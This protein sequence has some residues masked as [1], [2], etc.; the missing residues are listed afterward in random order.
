MSIA[1][2]ID[3]LTFRKAIIAWFR[4]ATDLLTVWREQSE[5]KADYPYGG[6][7]I[8]NG[9]MLLA[10]QWETRYE[11]DLGRD[12]GEEIKLTTRVPCNFVISCQAYVRKKDARDPNQDAMSYVNKAQSALS[13]LSVQ[14]TLENFNVT[15]IRTSDVQNISSVIGDAHV[16]R[17]NID[18]TFGATLLLEEFTGYIERVQTVSTT[19]G[20]DQIIGG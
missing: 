12:P 17:A 14:T 18:V 16:S 7:Q 19:L 9:P 4:N 11:T 15:Y 20:V 10:P 3:M 6:L 1:A 2:P 5:P 8:L 13:L